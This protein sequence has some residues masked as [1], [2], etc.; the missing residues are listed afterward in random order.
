[1]LVWYAG[2]LDP[3]KLLILYDHTQTVPILLSINAYDNEIDGI[4]STIEVTPRLLTDANIFWS[5]E[6]NKTI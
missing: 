6:E 1:L 3:D 5:R 4:M 2:R